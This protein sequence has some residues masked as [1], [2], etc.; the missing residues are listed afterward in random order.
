VQGRF[1]VMDRGVNTWNGL[2]AL[3]RVGRADC[4]PI[5]GVI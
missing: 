5:Q 2:I 3:K 4:A 1:T